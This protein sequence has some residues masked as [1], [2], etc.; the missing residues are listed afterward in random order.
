MSHIKGAIEEKKSQ[1]R[2]GEEYENDEAGGV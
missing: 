2:G 1:D